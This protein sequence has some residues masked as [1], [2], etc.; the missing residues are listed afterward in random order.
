MDSVTKRRMSE[1]E[2]QRIAQA[3]FGCGCV[4]SQELGEGW[5]N[6][7]YVL[8]L[9]DGRSAVL[10]AAAESEEGRMR[11][12]RGLMRTEVEVMRRV[13]S[14]GTVP[15]PDIHAY[16]ASKTIVPCEYF[17]MEKLSGVSYDKIREEMPEQEKE[18]IDRELGGYFRQI[19][20]VTGTEFGYYLPNAINSPA[21]DEAFIGLMRDVMQ[22]GKDAGIELPMSYEDL[23]SQL[24]KHRAALREV[25]TPRLI[26]WDSWSGNVF[27]KNGHVE[28]LID[29]ERALW[30]D[31]LMEYGFGKFGYSPVFEQAYAEADTRIVDAAQKADSA[32]AGTSLPEGSE[33]SQKIRRA[34]YPLY[35]DLVMRVECYYRGFGEEHTQWAQTNLQDGWE[36]F[37]RATQVG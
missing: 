17:L 5:A 15:L 10:K 14:L 27:V 35:L 12:E 32:V 33:S 37:L 13:K 34:L 22:D 4:R 28:S 1:D 2:L 3:N 24:E 36:R 19:H 26:H 31:P 30:A 18:I 29:F 8:D 23:D 9:E 25:K 16:D 6:S 11:C 7:A 20:S 21:W